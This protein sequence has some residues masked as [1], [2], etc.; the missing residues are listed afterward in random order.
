MRTAKRRPAEAA[1]LDQK[2]QLGFLRRK[3]ASLARVW[4]WTFEIT[5]FSPGLTTY[6]D[7]RSK[8]RKKLS[9]NRLPDRDI[10][11]SLDHIPHPSRPLP[12][13]DLETHV[14]FMKAQPPPAVG[15]LARSTEKLSK[16]SGELFNRARK[17]LSREQ[18]T[19]YRIPLHTGVKCH[20]EPQTS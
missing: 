14:R 16:E 17:R 19:E 18:R 1:W 15:M 13:S 12:L 10:V 8:K 5:G 6:A 9:P 4:H 11:E 3:V 2:M 7:D 20:R